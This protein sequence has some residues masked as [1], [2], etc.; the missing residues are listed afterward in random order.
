MLSE[1]QKKYLKQETIDQQRKHSTTHTKKF[2]L[3]P[4]F[5]GAVAWSFLNVYFSDKNQNK[6]R[7]VLIRRVMIVS[8][9]REWHQKCKWKKNAVHHK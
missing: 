6:N 4:L 3:F 8:V 5:L 1:K 2:A 9:R 7:V